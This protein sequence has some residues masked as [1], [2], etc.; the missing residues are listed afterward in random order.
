VFVEFQAIRQNKPPMPRFVDL[1]G[2]RFGRLI[3]IRRC[4]NRG[5][6]V[7]FLCRCD[8]GELVERRAYDLK[9]GRS[10][11]CGCLWRERCAPGARQI[12]THLLS[13]TAEY[14]SWDNML[15]RCY[16]PNAIGY[17]RTG[18]RGIKVCA[19]WRHSFESFIKDMGLRPS[20]KHRLDRKDLAGHYSPDN[21]HWVTRKEQSN[22]RRDNDTRQRLTSDWRPKAN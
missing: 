6:R 8:C 17:E 9:S 13:H 14:R 11:S 18:G 12:G 3:V 5:D 7:V 10:Q 19:R 16:N 22:N 15:S 1:S 4:A 20:W 2:S 21:C